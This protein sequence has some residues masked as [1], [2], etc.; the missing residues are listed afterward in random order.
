MPKK[1]VITAIDLGTEKCVT[2]IAVIDEESG[3]LKVVGV[4]AVPSKGMKRSMIVDLDLVL[5]TVSQSLDAAE[6]MA[7]F[8]V[9][10]VYLSVSGTH[11]SSR[12]SKG[13]VAVAAPDQE[14]TANDVERVIEAAR[15]ISLPA[16]RK[17]MHV[18]PRDFKVDSQEGIKDPVGMTGV[19]LESEA[20]IITG[21]TA[22]LRNLEKVVNDLGLDVDGFVFA[23][24][25]A[26]EV[27]LTETEKELGAIVVDMGAGTTSLSVFI[28]GAL[29][30][31]GA[32]PVGARHITQDIALGCRISLENAEKIKILLS[33]EDFSPVKPQAGE[34]KEDLT[35]RRKKADR[36]DLA[37]HDIH[38]GVEELS[39]KFL[40][41]GVMLPRMKEIFELIKKDLDKRD[42][43]DKV[44]AGLIL[45]GGGAQTVGMIEIAKRVFNLPVRVGEP[46][47]LQG[48]VGDIK[49]PSY[50]TSIG[51]LL[52]GK[53]KIA[54][55][56]ASGGM[57]SILE[58]IDLKGIGDKIRGLLK[59]VLP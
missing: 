23:G 33:G 36:L 56:P 51:L 46:T 16:D 41:E 5:A 54:V 59:S 39:K 26:S 18:I 7:G 30:Y 32:V 58:S 37:R 44:P 19:R 50:A 25:S 47:D 2:L 34:S 53:N 49:G 42:V 8:D 38:E 17:I 9:K 21:M 6:R 24:L 35:K 40:L 14:I 55:V 20:H 45:C 31:S 12:N 10:S 1:R 27:V 3:D 43:L 4:S 28:D 11:V 57:G 48:L 22:S 13:V 52:Y 15:A 29:E